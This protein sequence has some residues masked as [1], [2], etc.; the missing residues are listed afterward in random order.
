MARGDGNVFMRGR[1][2]WVEVWHHGRRVRRS[3]G[4]EKKS[5]AHTLRRKLLRELAGGRN[6]DA[7]RTTF[8]N[9]ATMLVDDY[10]ANG[11]ASLPRAQQAI[12][13]LREPFG[14]D[15][16]YA[17]TADRVSEY[18]ATRLDDGAARGTVQKELAALGRMFTL[19]DRAGRV[20]HRP[21]FPSIRVENTRAGF[22]EDHELR[23]VLS[24]LPP[25]I[26]PLVEF[27]YLTG[28]RVGEARQLEWRHVD[29]VAGTVRLE[30][31]TTKNREARTFPFD[32][33]PAL[34]ALLH[35][36]RAA[37]EATQHETGQIIPWVFHREGQPIR[38]FRW[39]WM[40]ACKKAGVP[41]KLVHDLRRT[42]VRNLER[43]GVARSHV[44]KLTG[45]KTEA[46]YRRY[47]I[48]SEAD[49]REAVRKLA[50]KRA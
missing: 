40:A 22:F 27:L 4:S 29:F 2:W 11:R 14:N 34:A 6:P 33:L 23:A 36:Q 7:E 35:R 15:R 50:A 47:A 20:T 46:V 28:W 31:C 13:H 41:G 37:T 8:E 5:D 1:V 12:A 26:A 9:L 43:A 24:H 32:A 30:P 44:M 39:A 45:H 49:L 19:A 16:A 17:I 38:D 18:I 10:R 25:A 48:V 3:S 21:R 42:A